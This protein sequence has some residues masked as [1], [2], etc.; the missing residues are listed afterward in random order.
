[1]MDSTDQLLLAILEIRDLIKLV[2]EPQIAARDQK[3]RDEL[4]RI[5]GKSA[6]K[7]KSVLLMDGNRSQ[8]VIRKQSKINQGHLSTLV[9]QL[10]QSKLLTGDTR[11]PKLAISVPSNFFEKAME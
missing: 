6:P 11:Q 4:V 9:K 5:V 10:A 3:L 1:M 2:A 7:A 8:V